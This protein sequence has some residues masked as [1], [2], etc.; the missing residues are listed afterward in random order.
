MGAGPRLKFP[1]DVFST[2]GGWYS[3]PKNWKRNTAIAFV[4]LWS[5]NGILYFLHD[6]HFETRTHNEKNITPPLKFVQQYDF[7]NHSFNQINKKVHQLN[8]E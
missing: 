6:K 4:C 5:F 8:K 7:E 3:N 1:K 2:Y